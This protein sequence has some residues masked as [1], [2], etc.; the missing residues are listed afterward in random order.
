MQQLLARAAVEFDGP[1]QS[2]SIV[3]LDEVVARLEAFRRQ[4][5]LPGSAV[6][7]LLQAQ[8]LRGRAYE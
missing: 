5:S 6:E 3:L 7:I 8:R 4:G 1:E 2:R